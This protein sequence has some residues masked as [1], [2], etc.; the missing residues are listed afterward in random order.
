LPE[1]VAAIENY[2]RNAPEKIEQVQRLR[3]AHRETA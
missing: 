1:N 2:S 3:L